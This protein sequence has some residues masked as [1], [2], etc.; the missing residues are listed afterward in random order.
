MEKNEKNN[1]IQEF[2]GR[3]L[4]EAISHAEHVLKRPR[5]Q[6]NYEIVTEKT[7]LFGIKGKEI[8]IRAWPKKSL[9]DSPAA[10]FLNRFLEI[11]PLELSYYL[12]ER[13]EMLFVI[14]DGQDKHL[15]LRK[16]GA[17][18]LAIQHILN[19]V[20]EA[21]VQIDCD[22]F[23]KRKEREI[24]ERAKQ[25]A[26]IVQETGREEIMDYMN[27]Y[28]RRIVHLTVNQIPGLATESLGEGFLKQIRV[29]PVKASEEMP[30]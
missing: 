12:K 5:S 8:V 13:N 22:F 7:K 1:T 29:Y 6:L 10:Q 17:L 11:F 24:R 15:L 23:K 19:K 16:D 20:S 4:E 27:P 18:L 25:A 28:E 26:R 30:R 14:F 2:K 3:N 9:E 21:K